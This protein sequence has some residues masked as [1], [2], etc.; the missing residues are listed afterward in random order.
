MITR[1]KR[2]MNRLYKVIMECVESK[3]LQLVS[4]DDATT[5]H[6]RLGHIGS[7]SLKTM[8]RK[9]LVI[10]L[11]KMTVDKE[12]CASCFFA[13]QARRPF[14]QATS[15]RADQV[16]ELV[17]G[18]LCGPISPSTAARNRYI[19]VII[20]DHSRYM[21]SILLK[22]KG[23][24]FTKFKIFK[25]LVELETKM[26]I[27]CF[28]TDRGG[29]FTSTEFNEFCEE[30][31]I[32]KHLT[33]PYSPQQNGVVE[34]RNRTLMEMTR[35]LL[36]HMSMPNHLW[37]EAVRHAT[38]LINR[39]ATRVL[40]SQTPYEIFKGKKP[41]IDHLRVFGCVC[42]VKV[43][44]PFVK[45]LDDR[46]RTLVHMGIKPASKAYRLYDPKNRRTVMSRDVHFDETKIWEWKSSGSETQEDQPGAFRIAIGDYGNRGVRE[47]EIEETEQDVDGEIIEE[48]EEGPSV[49]ISDGADDMEEEFVPLRRSTR[50]HKPLSYLEDYVYLAEVEGESL[51]LLLNDEPWDFNSFI[52]EKVWRDACDE[53]IAAI[54]KNKTW[55]LVDLPPGAKA[56]GL[57]WIFKIKRNT[58]GS[59]NKHKSRLV[60]K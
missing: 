53:E 27:K 18:D 16:L 41:K 4:M 30:N 52:E 22:D 23:E 29:E 1:A 21:W 60:A 40:V 49:D 43:D 58:D 37:G 50:V 5:W 8:V 24:A 20:D 45:K 55:H 36:K 12:T 42:Y 28:R 51:L 9:E 7:E 57:K 19:F 48:Q 56:I 25:T 15:Y 14:P 46:S 38:Y 13:K 32:L 34:R 3:C 26:K 47:T 39:V 10:G 59:I 35:S 6:A 44:T 31:G 2:A 11:P 33:A 54:V 17:H